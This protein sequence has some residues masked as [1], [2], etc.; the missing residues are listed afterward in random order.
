[1]TCS[2]ARMG[3]IMKCMGKFSLKNLRDGGY[4]GVPHVDWKMQGVE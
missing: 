4:F 1:V 2:V 3:C